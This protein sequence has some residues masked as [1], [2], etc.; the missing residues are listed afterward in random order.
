MT[1]TYL[2][3][4]GMTETKRQ[5]KE[6]HIRKKPVPAETSIPIGISVCATLKWFMSS[7]MCRTEVQS[8]EPAKTKM[9]PKTEKKADMRNVAVCLIIPLYKR[10]RIKQPYSQQGIRWDEHEKCKCGAYGSKQQQ[11][12]CCS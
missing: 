9:V 12:I 4:Y 6:A 10:C 7:D 5:A 3:M 8:A 1:R 11:V 2:M